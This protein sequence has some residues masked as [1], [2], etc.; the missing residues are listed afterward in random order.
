MCQESFGLSAGIFQKGKHWD[1][2]LKVF[3]RWK[4]ESAG[5]FSKVQAL[6]FFN[7]VSTASF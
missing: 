6:E 4:F 5:H 1:F 3:K 7:W 2:S